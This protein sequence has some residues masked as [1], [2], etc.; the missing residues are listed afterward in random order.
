MRLYKEHIG[1]IVLFHSCS[2]C[3]VR[4]TVVDILK[5][6]NILYYILKC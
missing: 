5:S 4:R 2:I 3:K 1:T 6:T